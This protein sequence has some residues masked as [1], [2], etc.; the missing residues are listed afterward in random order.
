VFR[1]YIAASYGLT[2]HGRDPVTTAS[3]GANE[4]ETSFQMSAL[5]ESRN[6]QSNGRVGDHDYG[7]PHS[8]TGAH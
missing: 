3:E 8:T 4:A 5:F 6:S 1:F 2:L 7:A